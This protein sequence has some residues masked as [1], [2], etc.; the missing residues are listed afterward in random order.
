[1][2]KNLFNFFILKAGFIL[3]LLLACSMVS[4]TTTDKDTIDVSGTGTIKVP[5][6]QVEVSLAVVT[7][8]ADV[9]Q[10]QKENA[11]KMN[12][13]ISGLKSAL[14]LSDDEIS[15]SYYSV[16]EEWNPST[17]LKTTYGEDVQIYRVSNTITVVTS[18]VDKVGDIIDV[19]I[20]NG[21]NS[22]DSLQ[23]SLT[24][25]TRKQHHQEAL[26]IAVEKTKE[27]ANAIVKALGRTLGQAAYVQIGDNYVTSYRTQMYGL[28]ETSASADAQAFTPIQAGQVE[29][30]AS[31]SVTYV[32]T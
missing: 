29:V 5:A 10:I 31:V 11:K 12:N 16:S 24:A 27:D 22:V 8:G 13:I 3:L 21:A 20:A 28:K 26:Q 9:N 32:M 14:R 19:A 17:A 18:N 6:D 2:H 15:T 1:M 23:F 7:K 25:D 30:S 4:A